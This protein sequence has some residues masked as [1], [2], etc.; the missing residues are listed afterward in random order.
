MIESARKYV[1]RPPRWARD[2]STDNIEF[3]V[4]DAAALP[5]PDGYFDAV[6]LFDVLLHIPEWRRVIAEVYRV[7]KPGG[8]FSFT[9]FILSPF[10]NGRLRHV[11]FGESELKESLTASGLS[12]QSFERTKRFPVVFVRAVK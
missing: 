3:L 2:I 9:D 7:L 6:F 5:F 10:W 8:V 11:S 12:I 4:Q 1:A